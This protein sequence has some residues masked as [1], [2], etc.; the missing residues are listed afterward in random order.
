MRLIGMLDSPFVRRVGVSMRLMRLEFSHESMSVFRHFDQFAV[1][2][3][4]QPCR[5]NS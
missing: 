3:R 5:K 4:R 1:A 2:A